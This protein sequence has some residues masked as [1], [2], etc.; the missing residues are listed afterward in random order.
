MG[1]QV[2]LSIGHVVGIIISA[3]LLTGL[4]VGAIFSVETAP[5]DGPNPLFGSTGY[6]PFFLSVVTATLLTVGAWHAA[7]TFQH[8]RRAEAATRFQKG[9]EMLGNDSTSTKIAGLY[10]LRDLARDWPSLYLATVLNTVVSFIAQ[11]DRAYKDTLAFFGG[12]GG[13]PIPKRTDRSTVRALAVLAEMNPGPA[14]SWPERA[15]TQEGRLLVQ[16]LSVNHVQRTG[17]NYSGVDFRHTFIGK[18]YFIKC[19]LIGSAMSAHIFDELVFT[20]CDL[21]GA[22][23]EFYDIQLDKQ[24]DPTKQQL[25][26]HGGTATGAT[27]NGK[28]AS[29][30]QR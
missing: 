7:R 15:N 12:A 4:V 26:I 20:R 1:R 16:E 13:T 5:A 24:V 11:N 10:V 9:A 3:V 2:Q 23:L 6:L 19:D 25:R 29:L 28:P 18:V 30:W 17:E 8:S 21:A 14:G 22:R 27:V